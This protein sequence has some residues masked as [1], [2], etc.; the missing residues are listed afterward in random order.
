ML[1]L[2]VNNRAV[3]IDVSRFPA[4]ETHLRI[5]DDAPRPDKPPHVLIT[6]DF[7]GNDDLVNLLLLTDAARRLYAQGTRQP[8][9]SLRMNYLPYARQDRVNCPGEPLSIK[10][11]A[12]I[13]N[14]QRYQAIYCMDVHSDVSLALLNNVQHWQSAELAHQL[15]AAQVPLVVVAPDAGAA[16]RARAFA[17]V[18]G[19]SKVVT[20]EKIRNPDGG[21]ITGTAVHCSFQGFSD[22]L[23]VD[24]ICDGGATFVA[25]ATELRKLTHGRVFLYVTHGIFSKGLDRFVGLIDGIYTA[26]N[27]ADCT[28]P[29]LTT[30]NA[31]E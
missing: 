2:H 27:M 26:N 6:C 23:I 1:S 17:E 28:H 11:I 20:A 19:A 30:L 29:L 16:R 18:A 4:G 9:I 25:L 22:F 14:A 21:A 31:K 13:L 24:D 10:V 5:R 8:G 3:D 12:N 15:C 7:Q